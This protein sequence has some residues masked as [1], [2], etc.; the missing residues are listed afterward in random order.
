MNWWATA[1]PGGLVVVGWV[2]VARAIAAQARAING[3]TERVAFLEA[4]VNGLKR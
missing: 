4:K 3:L 2:L 1:V